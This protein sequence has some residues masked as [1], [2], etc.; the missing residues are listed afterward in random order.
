MIRAHIA[1]DHLG[2]EVRVFILNELKSRTDIL[3]SSGDQFFVWEELD[4]RGV[5]V[6]PSFTLPPLA[7]RALLD[8]LTKHFRGASDVH[9]L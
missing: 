5:T 7:A 6:Q 4:D 1:E 8:G 3:R 9:Q 2:R